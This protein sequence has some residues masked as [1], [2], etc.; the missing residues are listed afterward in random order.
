MSPS[1]CLIAPVLV[2]IRGGKLLARGSIDHW[3]TL[4]QPSGPRMS[5]AEAE[6]HYVT[7]L[8]D[9]LP[10]LGAGDSLLPGTLPAAGPHEVRVCHGLR[11]NESLLEIRMDYTCG[12]RGFV[13][14]VNG[15]CA[16]FL[17][18]GREVAPEAEQVI[19]R[20]G[21]AVEAG[22]DQ[23]QGGQEFAR[24]LRIQLRELR[25]DLG[26][27]GDDLRLLAVA[28]DGRAQ[29]R[30]KCVPLDDLMFRHVRRVQ[31]RFR[32]EEVEGA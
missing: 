26:G 18:T 5:I 17:L 27:E 29:R 12:G 30:D 1:F 28:L 10:A 31:D 3:M 32:S 13:P 22:L 2:W 16:D 19:R 25:L 20:M 14:S 15:P 9:V 24:V 11:P 7:I 21:E 6:K 8:H 4:R 23:A